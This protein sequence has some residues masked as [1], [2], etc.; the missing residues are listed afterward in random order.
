MKRSLLLSFLVFLAVSS[1]AHAMIFP[2]GPGGDEGPGG[3]PGGGEDVVRLTDI[4]FPCE[5]C[6]FI[7]AQAIAIKEAPFNSCDIWR[8]GSSATYCEA[9]MQD[10][11]IPVTST[12]H[13]YRFIVSVTI[14]SQNRNEVRA[15]EFPFLSS[16]Q[17]TL[18]NMFFD[19]N[20]ELD[21][22]LAN[23]SIDTSI[24]NGEMYPVRA[25]SIPDSFNTGGSVGNCSAH[26]T[27]WFREAQQRQEI[28][29]ELTIKI[30][31]HISGQ[32]QVELTH[33]KLLN[34][35]GVNLSQGGAGVQIGFKYFEKDQV[36]T[37]GEYPHNT[38]AFKVQFAGDI[39]RPNTLLFNFI[40]DKRFTRIDGFTF[41]DLFVD[42]DLVGASMSDCLR[43]FLKDET[44]S[45]PQE[46]RLPDGGSGTVDDPFTGANADNSD[47]PTMICRYK[48]SIRVCSTTEEDQ[49]T[50]CMYYTIKWQDIC[51]FN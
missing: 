28:S 49:V 20:D 5:N 37:Y 11:L 24:G 2:G 36:I 7:E 33:D 32:T 3:G 38:L 48:K 50:T 25:Y 44:E 39:S 21:F 1:S 31:P 22:A 19:L 46:Q 43:D 12:K 35:G 45:L 27:Q 6:T 42:G 9:V 15:F 16:N 40:L 14:D 30:L 34:S 26:P 17:T 18:T 51:S 13:V 41:G 4:A 29:D 10:I 8:N 47:S 23:A